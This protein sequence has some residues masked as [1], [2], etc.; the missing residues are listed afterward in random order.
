LDAVWFGCAWFTSVQIVHLFGISRNHARDFARKASLVEDCFYRLN[1]LWSRF[2]LLAATLSQKMIQR[3]RQ[4]A[5]VNALRMIPTKWAIAIVVAAIGYVLLQPKLNDW[6]GLQLPSVASLVGD[7]KTIPAKE[8]PKPARSEKSSPPAKSI[9]PQTESEP[10]AKSSSANDENDT[11]KVDGLLTEIGRDRFESPAGLV[12]APGSEEG[13]RL[14]HLARHLE[15]QPDRPGSHGV[16]D[17]DMKEFLIAIDD[18][19]SRAK[20]GAKGTKKTE[21]DG[22]TVYEA[23]FDKAIGFLGGE[24]GGRKRKP[25]LKRL[26]IVV[27][28]NS[29]ITAFPIQ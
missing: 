16:F 23:S 4:D 7:E 12:Y 29:V 18:G 21:D 26:R 3:Q 2:T 15:D 8:K 28:G 27:R 9:P 20:R 24:A 5:A 19:Y 22:S 14:K 13:H 25:A 1:C 10:P 11:N 6:F 17:G